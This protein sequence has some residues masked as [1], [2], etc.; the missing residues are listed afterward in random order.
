MQL[1]GLGERCKLPQWGLERRPSRQTIWCILESES[2]AL[3]IFLRTDVIFCTAGPIPH[4]AAAYEECFTL[5]AVATIAQ[6]KWAAP[7]DET[8]RQLWRISTNL[9]SSHSVC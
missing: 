2:A 5:G 8:E 9:A 1:V 6:W 3:L 4:R 7:M